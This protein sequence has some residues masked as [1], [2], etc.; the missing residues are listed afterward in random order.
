M[1]DMKLPL[2]SNKKAAPAAPTKQTMNFVHHE[3]SFNPTKMLLILVVLVL[4]GGIFAKL[5][6]LDPLDKKTAA[7]NELSLKQDQLAAV[8]AK[9]TGFDDLS[10]EYGRYSYGWMNESEISMVSRMD[11]LDLVESKIAS[12]AVID[13]LAVN[14]NILTLNIHGVT[15]E[16]ASRMVKNL[17]SSDL[18]KTATVYNA[19][20]ESAEDA[21]IFMS[22]TLTKEVE[23]E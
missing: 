15:P 16:Q 12:Q 13:D 2:K 1:A 9:L 3:S 20:A 4:V 8:N 14:N 21:Q 18:V 6:I 17:E 5:G 19:V 23:A 10:L 7:L 22:I 11:V